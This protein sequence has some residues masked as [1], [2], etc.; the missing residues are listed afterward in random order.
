MKTIF[1]F[2]GQGAQYPGMGQ[3]LYNAD[4]NVRQL[5]DE[6][7]DINGR[8]WAKILFDSSAEELKATD[9]AQVAIILVSMAASMALEAR[10]IT[11]SACAGFSL[12]EYTALY[13]AGVL[14]RGDL[15]R[16][17]DKRGKLLERISRTKDT[18]DG[19][20]GMSAVLG[21]D[22]EKIA[23]AINGIDDVYI[24]L[25]SSPNQ[26]VLSGT[27]AGLS[28]AEE[29]LEEA[30][31]M[32]QVKLMV[33]GPFHSPLLEDAKPEFSE[34]LDGIVFSDPKIPIYV[35]TTAATA[36]R[37]DELR[38]TCL[39]QLDHCVRWVDSQKALMD[40]NPDQVLE[41][42]PGTVLTGL[43]KNMRSKLRAR[44]AGKLDAIEGL[45]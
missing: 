19:P 3:D 15:L 6:A 11:A 13:Q 39:D 37:G 43:W 41:V 27:A 10:G 8:D 35:N 32:K 33:S 12:G 29:K 30:G 5:F 26:S 38:Q 45:L 23:M 16:V 34:F 2:P 36:S 1:L 21:L 24:A 28:K 7:S 20:V 40:L 31:A 4:L 22:R 18:P 14:T 17:V 9:V 42:G 25:H 44:P